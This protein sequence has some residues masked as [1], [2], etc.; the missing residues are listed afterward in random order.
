MK[1]RIKNL[2]G[3]T[4]N[5]IYGRKCIIKEITAKEAKIFLDLNHI[6][7]NVNA[8]IKVGLFYDNEL[9]SLMTFGGLRKSMGGVSDVGSYE[10]LRF[11]NKL[12]STIIGGAD[13]LL[14]YFIKTYDPKKLISY[15]DR[16]W[17]TGNLYEKLGFTFI[18]DSKPSYYYI[19]NNRREYRF[20]Y[21]KD[22]LI[23]EGYDGSKTEREIMIER[24]LYRIYDC[25]A[26]RYELIFS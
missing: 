26:K 22:I 9:V 19:V 8:R 17:S 6:Q 2:L 24:G 13:K 15:A 3:L 4:D 23:S 16:R 20:K 10:L 21:R 7:G 12:D 25:G 5:R 11:C 18:H 1:S 14:K